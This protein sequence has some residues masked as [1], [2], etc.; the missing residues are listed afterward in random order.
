ML[1]MGWSCRVLIVCCG[2][3]QGWCCVVIVCCGPEQ[4][5]CCV[6]TVCCGN[7]QGLCCAVI[8]CCGPGIV[9]FWGTNSVHRI[10]C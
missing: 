2:P 8:V 3:E 9:L 6:V 5:L 4:G 10:F 7:E 1:Y